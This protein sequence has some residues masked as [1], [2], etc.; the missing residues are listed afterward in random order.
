LAVEVQPSQAGQA[1]SPYRHALFAVRRW[2]SRSRFCSPARR[3][4][5]GLGLSIVRAIATAH[6]T[7]ITA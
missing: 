1:V 7:T 4:G 6:G 3:D 2:A 5:R